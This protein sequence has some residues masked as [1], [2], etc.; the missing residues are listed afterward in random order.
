MGWY[1]GQSQMGFFGLQR[2]PA[3]PIL[4]AGIALALF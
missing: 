2:H 4:R 1:A 3:G